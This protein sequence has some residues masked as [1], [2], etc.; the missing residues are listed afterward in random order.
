M[1]PDFV[2]DVINAFSKVKGEIDKESG[3]FDST[4]TV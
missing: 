3:E 4:N 2:K 1:G